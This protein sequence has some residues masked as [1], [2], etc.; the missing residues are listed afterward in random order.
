MHPLTKFQPPVL[1]NHDVIR[2]HIGGIFYLHTLDR[3]NSLLDAMLVGCV[4]SSVYTQNIHAPTSTINVEIPDSTS[5][6]D[7][8]SEII[9]VPM[10][11][12]AKVIAF[13]DHFSSDSFNGFSEPRFTAVI[14]AVCENINRNAINPAIPVNTILAL[15]FYFLQK[16]YLFC[17]SRAYIPHHQWIRATDLLNNLENLKVDRWN[18]LTQGFDN[19]PISSIHHLIYSC[20]LNEKQQL[21]LPS[22]TDACFPFTVY[23]KGIW[24][25]LYIINDFFSR[26]NILVM[27]S[28]NKKMSNFLETILGNDL[29]NRDLCTNRLF[30]RDIPLPFTEKINE[31]WEE[32]VK[33]PRHTF[34]YSN[35]LGGY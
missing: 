7:S 24:F 30:F 5:D 3:N 35:L 11:T 18:T 32:Y 20:N 31:Y 13:D 8:I 25:P 14:S 15:T 2:N 34:Q 4:D 9:N 21:H 27:I 26:R 12:N 28:F 19:I 33:S 1:Y 29:F 6:F 22:K 10:S 23:K 16:Q 17:P